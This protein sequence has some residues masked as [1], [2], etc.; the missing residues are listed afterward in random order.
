MTETSALS[1]ETVIQTGGKGKVELGSTGQ[2]RAA[3][4]TWFVVLHWNRIPGRGDEAAAIHF[5]NR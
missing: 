5:T 2:P 1:F 3:V 4:P